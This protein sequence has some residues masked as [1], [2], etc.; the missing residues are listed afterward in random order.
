MPLQANCK[1]IIDTTISYQNIL[2]YDKTVIP[3]HFPSNIPTPINRD[4]NG[5]HF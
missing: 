2:Y 3:I 4:R 1:N 5:K